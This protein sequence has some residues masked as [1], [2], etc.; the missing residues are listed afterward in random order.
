MVCWMAF[1]DKVKRL[2][3]VSEKDAIAILKQIEGEIGH[4]KLL[5]GAVVDSEG[6][7]LTKRLKKRK[8]QKEEATIAY[9]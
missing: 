7:N 8:R 3:G 5:I 4:N 2:T 9:V 1:L 6:A